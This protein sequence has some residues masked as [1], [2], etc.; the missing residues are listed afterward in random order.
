M[1][2]ISSSLVSKAQKL[3]LTDL[4]K[5]LYQSG[6][7]L[8]IKFPLLYNVTYVLII[9]LAVTSDLLSCNLTKYVAF[10]LPLKK[11]LNCLSYSLYN[12]CLPLKV[13]AKSLQE[14]RR[15][16]RKLSIFFF[17]YYYFLLFGYKSYT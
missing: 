12:S 4:L 8:R 10:F 17:C 6:F 16:I 1:D 9:L 3:D 13:P 15:L 14:F 5:Q 11:N 7:T 2:L